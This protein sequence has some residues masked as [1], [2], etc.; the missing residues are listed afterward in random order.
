M[1]SSTPTKP[2]KKQEEVEN[3]FTYKFDCFVK[4]LGPDWPLD[5]IHA[6]T[7]SDTYHGDLKSL[8]DNGCSKEL[9]IRILL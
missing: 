8:L 1:M 7:E 2:D 4:L 9:A 5:D 3:L 6:L